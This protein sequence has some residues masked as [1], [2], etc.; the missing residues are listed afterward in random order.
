MAMQRL[1]NAR[2]IS[3]M[4]LIIRKHS[5]SLPFKRGILCDECRDRS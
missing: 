3:P 2:I 5:L 4:H 1:E